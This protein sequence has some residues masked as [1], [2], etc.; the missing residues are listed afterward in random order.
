MKAVK[1]KK[2]V[3][4]QFF[5]KNS[6]WLRKHIVEFIVKSN[7]SVLFDPFAGDGDILD[8]VSKTTGIKKLVGMDI[9]KKLN[10][11]INDSLINIPRVNNS[12]IVTNP[13]YLSN[14]SASR[15]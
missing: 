1:K 14:Y 7:K 9:D 3:Y 15:K 12:I 4:G 10:W 13:P 6:V 5:T 2:I 11:K 8:A